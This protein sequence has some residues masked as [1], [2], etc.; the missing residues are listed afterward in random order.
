MGLAI[1]VLGLGAWGQTLADLVERQGH[2]VRSWSRRSGG[3]PLEVIQ[4]A[5]LVLVAV[6]LQGVSWPRNSAPAGQESH[7]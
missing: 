5:D 6:A 4:G 3:S 1:G 2:Q 7:W